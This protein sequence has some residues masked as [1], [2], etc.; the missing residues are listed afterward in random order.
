MKKKSLKNKNWF[1]NTIIYQIN[2]FLKKRECL[3]NFKLSQNSFAN[4]RKGRNFGQISLKI[5]NFVK[6]RNFCH[7]PKYWSKI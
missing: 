2:E 7:K 5:E 3:K 1:K 6:N 4:N